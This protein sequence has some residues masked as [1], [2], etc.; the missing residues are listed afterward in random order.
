MEIY[1]SYAALCQRIH[2]HHVIH[3][4][5]EIVLNTRNYQLS[6]S[7]IQCYFVRSEALHGDIDLNSCNYIYSGCLLTNKPKLQVAQNNSLR[8]IARVDYNFSTKS[9]HSDLR[10]DWIDVTV[11]KT[12]CIEMFKNVHRLNRPRNCER[13]NWVCHELQ[14]RSHAQSELV[15]THIKTKRGEQ[16]MFYRG[17]QAWLSLPVEIRELDTWS[18]VR[19]A[20]KMLDGFLHV[21]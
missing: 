11:D 18:G 12:L 6:F 17:P 7:D 15:I 16:N 21:R 8:A 1:P 20:V 14:L 3:K 9:L 5:S 10:I 2:P 4:A 13:V 19:T